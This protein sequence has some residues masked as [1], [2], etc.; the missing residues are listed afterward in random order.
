MYFRV[1]F[2]WLAGIWL[3]ELIASHWKNWK[4][5]FLDHIIH[6]IIANSGNDKHL[7]VLSE[8]RAKGEPISYSGRE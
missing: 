5:L 1:G 6:K 4:A 8:S 7:L 2:L 3:S